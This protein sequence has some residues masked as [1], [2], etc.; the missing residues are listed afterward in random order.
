MP[1]TDPQTANHFSAAFGL[2]RSLDRTLIEE[3]ATSEISLVRHIIY[4][5]RLVLRY[6]KTLLMFIWTSLITFVMLPLLEHE[7]LPFFV[8]FA[9]GYLV[10]SLLVMRVARLPLGWIYR[11]LHGIPDEKYIDEQLVILENQIRRFCQV[12]VVCSTSALILSVVLHA[13]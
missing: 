7:E 6:M 12:A 3:V 1:E 8:I 13:G 10:W 5:R 2:A 11:H 4:L 9:G